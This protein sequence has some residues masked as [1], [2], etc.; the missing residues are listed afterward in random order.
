MSIVTYLYTVSYTLQSNLSTNLAWQTLTSS[1]LVSGKI[2]FQYLKEK[3][4]YKF[5]KNI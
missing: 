2:R 4:D 5:I 1:D 3:F